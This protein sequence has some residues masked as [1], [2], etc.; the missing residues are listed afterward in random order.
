MSD[1]LKL[2]KRREFLRVAQKGEKVVTTSLV[3][4][5]ARSLSKEKIAPKFGFTTSKKIGHAV[6]RNKTRRR[7]RAAVRELYENYTLDNTEYVIIGRYSTATCQFDTLLQDLK[8]AFK[9]ANKLI[10]PKKDE[11]D[12]INNINST[13]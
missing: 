10:Y 11:K 4:Q 12:N 13:N 1:F 8:Y 9:K 5:A 6:V 3:L 7:L 2:K